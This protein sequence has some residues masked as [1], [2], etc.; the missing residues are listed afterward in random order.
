[1]K[2]IIGFSLLILLLVSQISIAQKNNFGSVKLKQ[3]SKP[4]LQTWANTLPEHAI[5]TVTF[6]NVDN[7]GNFLLGDKSGNLIKTDSE[8]MILNIYHSQYSK[9]TALGLNGQIFSFQLR[10]YSK[11]L[12]ILNKNL[13]RQNSYMAEPRFFGHP[14]DTILVDQKNRIFVIHNDIDKKKENRIS[15]YDSKMRLQKSWIAQDLISSKTGVL[16]SWKITSNNTLLAIDLENFQLV[17]LNHHG[18]LIRTTILPEALIETQIDQVKVDKAGR[19]VF[20]NND[21]A[22]LTFYSEQGVHLYSIKLD[23]PASALPAL[24]HLAFSPAGQIYTYNSSNSKICKFDASG[25]CLGTL[26]FKTLDLFFKDFQPDEINPSH[27]EI[28]CNGNH[29]EMFGYDSETKILFK[30]RDKG[31]VLATYN[32]LCNKDRAIAIYIDIQDHIWIST[33]F[34]LIEMSENGEILETTDFSAFTRNRIKDFVVTESGRVYLIT[35]DN[36]LR[37]ESGTIERV[38]L[39]PFKHARNIVL[40][41]KHEIFIS[42]K[43]RILRLDKDE[44]LQEVFTCGEIIRS[45]GINKKNQFYLISGSYWQGYYGFNVYSEAGE[46]QFFTWISFDMPEK[47]NQLRDGR[48]L[49]AYPSWYDSNLIILNT[50]EKEIKEGRTGNVSGTINN[51]NNSGILKFYPN[52]VFIE[53]TTPKG[54]NFYGHCNTFSDFFFKDIPLGSKYRVWVEPDY[55]LSDRYTKPVYT[56]ELHS[57]EAQVYFINEPIPADLYLVSGRVVDKFGHGINGAVISCGAASAVSNSYGC[58][59][60]ALAPNQSHTIRVKH[61]GYKFKR[62]KITLPLT[63]RDKLYVDFQEKK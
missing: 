18:D 12:T 63:T 30:I 21:E 54:K 49:F 11:Q 37:L 28:L 27:C 42:D 9:M 7:D 8:G 50:T 23:F 51:D 39:P 48:Y 32:S 34:S 52:D 41:S 17:E 5:K 43:F 44:K 59:A 15:R 36:L 45:F 57:K 35:K 19:F 25:N 62:S 24:D 47:V 38:K 55:P 2:K 13:R 4:Y 26:S 53:G 40:N 33:A 3:D 31:K 61:P 16:R 22:K 58:Y 60:I 20:I 46:E 29:G 14:D 1:M 6:F 56:R 10:D